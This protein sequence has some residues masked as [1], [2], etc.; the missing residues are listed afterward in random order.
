VSTTPL[1]T[2]FAEPTILGEHGKNVMGQGSVSRG[3]QKLK[4][5][6][7]VVESVAEAVMKSAT[8]LS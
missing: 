5:A 2:G 6:Q 3:L 8:G 7:V 1:N 4:P